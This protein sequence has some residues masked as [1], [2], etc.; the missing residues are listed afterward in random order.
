M[1]TVGRWGKRVG[2]ET[3]CVCAGLFRAEAAYIAP[4][5]RPASLPHL[6]VSSPTRVWLEEVGADAVM[7]YCDCVI[8]QHEGSLA[9]SKDVTAPC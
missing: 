1:R 4:D 9:E 2:Y 6:S 3:V 7:D 8:Q 5:T